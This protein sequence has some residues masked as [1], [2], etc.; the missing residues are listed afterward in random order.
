[1]RL[2]KS[3]LVIF[4]LFNISYANASDEEN[5]TE[6]IMTM[7]RLINGEMQKQFTGQYGTSLWNQGCPGV[8]LKDYGVVF[9]TQV[10]FPIFNYHE[11]KS[12]QESELTDLWEKYR[13]NPESRT[14]RFYSASSQT[15]PNYRQNQVEQIKRLE[16]LLTDII[17]HYALKI[18]QL[19]ENEYFTIAVQGNPNT[20]FSQISRTVVMSKTDISTI[21]EQTPSTES[22]APAVPP[23]TYSERLGW[24]NNMSGTSGQSIVM[25]IK[26]KDIDSNCSEKI[27]K[28]FF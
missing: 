1:M 17:C 11:V 19:S 23:I 5:I 21:S 8:Y 7:S 15:S 27:E 26:K 2:L 22:P 18:E 14:Q 9:F 6:N 13:T 10:Q 16:K 4:L 24:G 12:E 25:R 28:Y 3:L 20:L